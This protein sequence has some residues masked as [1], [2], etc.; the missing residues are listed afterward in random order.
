MTSRGRSALAAGCGTAHNRPAGLRGRAPTPRSERRL[1][2][3]PAAGS[4][5]LRRTGPGIG[6]GTAG[7]AAA[8]CPWPLLPAPG[9]RRSPGAH[10]V[11]A[12]PPPPLPPCP[13]SFLPPALPGQEVPGRPRPL[14]RPRDACQGVVEW[15]DARS[16]KSLK[17]V[18]VCNTALESLRE[19]QILVKLSGFSWKE[20]PSRPP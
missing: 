19:F 5:H 18:T 6:I 16:W 14:C 2:R 8:S 10:H 15:R 11:A 1:H 12:A 4:T 20:I 3:P 13:P 7:A 17:C 9:R